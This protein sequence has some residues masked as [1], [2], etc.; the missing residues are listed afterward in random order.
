SAGNCLRS[1]APPDQD[2]LGQAG[3]Q[4]LALDRE[5][6]SRPPRSCR[7]APAGATGSRSCSSG[8]SGGPPSH[9]PTGHRPWAGR[10][11][12]W[13]PPRCTLPVIFPAPTKWNL[14]CSPPPVRFVILVNLTLP[15]KVPALWPVIIQELLWLGPVNV[16]MPPSPF[17]VVVAIWFRFTVKAFSV[18]PPDATPK[19][20]LPVVPLMVTESVPPSPSRATMPP[21]GANVPRSTPFRVTSTRDAE[22][23]VK[24]N[25]SLPV[26]PSTT[27]APAR[28]RA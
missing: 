27:S 23:G 22:T 14:S 28:S 4:R 6:G 18:M 20:S 8:S 5:G 17:R 19:A 2:R 15:S 21:V 3:V 9:R 7:T 1:A 12:R 10:P 26:V 24:T 25:A 11:N 16:L 13:C